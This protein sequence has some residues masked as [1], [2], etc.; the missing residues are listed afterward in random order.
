MFDYV[1]VECELPDESAKGVRE[2]Q[3]KEFDAPMMENYRI[4]AEGRLMEE[5]YHREDLS[6]PNAA[7][8][9]IESIIGCATLVHDGWRDLNFHGVLRFC[10]YVGSNYS[11]ENRHEY[12]AT[13]THGQLETIER[14]QPPATTRS[15]G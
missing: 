14:V 5:L 6:D 4:T 3:T 10:G 2:W 15:E 12:N 11:P 13:F 9:S 1:V 8:G 7:P